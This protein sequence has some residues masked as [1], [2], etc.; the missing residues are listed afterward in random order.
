MWIVAFVL[1]A[2]VVWWWL[3]REEKATK[4]AETKARDVLRQAEKHLK[5]AISRVAD[6]LEE[7]L[8]QNEG[9]TPPPTPNQESTPQQPEAT[10]SIE[11]KEEKEEVAPPPAPSKETPTP[12]KPKIAPKA[13]VPV[14]VT[15]ESTAPSGTTAES[16]PSYNGETTPDDLTKIEG[17]GAYYRDML[18]NAG[19]TTFEALSKLSQAEID[20]IIKQAGG[21]KSASTA[22]WAEQATLAAKGHWEALSTLQSA[23][24]GGR[25]S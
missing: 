22:T 23:L 19:I 5:E 3:N 24:K 4:E 12:P 11:E 8:E 21:R 20:A 14:V 7:V 2:V 17:I 25:K 10:E 13:D 18:I 9:I 15:P 6:K 1:L 16:S